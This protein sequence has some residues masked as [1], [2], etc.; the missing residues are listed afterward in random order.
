ME[1]FFCEVFFYYSFFVF[2]LE[3]KRILL[4]FYRTRSLS[5]LQ[6]RVSSHRN[7]LCHFLVSKNE[8]NELTAKRTWFKIQ[9][10]YSYSRQTKK[11]NQSQPIQAALWIQNYVIINT[12]RREE[13]KKNQIENVKCSIEFHSYRYIWNVLVI[14]VCL[15]DKKH[16][17]N[18]VNTEYILLKCLQTPTC[19][20]IIIIICCERWASISHFCLKDSN[21]ISIHI[22]FCIIKTTTTKINSANI[23]F[24][25][26]SI[27]F[28][29]SLR[30]MWLLCITI[31]LHCQLIRHLNWSITY[32]Y[33]QWTLKTQWKF[34]E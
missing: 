26:I 19:F 16:R 6:V 17:N 22:L 33:L 18:D 24:I 34:W 11:L 10:L 14:L 9:I 32:I 1:W 2:I 28:S 30:L 29:L 27:T 8:Q 31:C 25:L 3:W 4:F 12:L 13:R 7:N 20:P 21:V 15:W 23:P 5:S